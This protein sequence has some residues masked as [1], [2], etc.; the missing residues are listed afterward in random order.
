MTENTIIGSQEIPGFFQSFRACEVMSLETDAESFGR[1]C[2]YRNITTSAFFSPLGANLHL[3]FHDLHA[4]DQSQKKRLRP[5][6]NSSTLFLM[7]NFGRS[8]SVCF[9]TGF[10]LMCP[11]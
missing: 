3:Q 10:D 6:M 7:H 2:M 9:S 8:L 1:R 4:S 5:R 11:P